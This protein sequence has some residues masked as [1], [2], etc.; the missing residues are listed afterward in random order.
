M[1]DFR[2]VVHSALTLGFFLDS[3]GEPE[4]H[5]T[6]GSW[7]DLCGMSV[8][9]AMSGLDDGEGGGGQSGKTKNII[10]FTMQK[11]PDNEYSLYLTASQVPNSDV[12]VSFTMDGEPK[13]VTIPA[14]TNML[15]TGLK[16]KNPSKP[17]AVIS[18]AAANSDDEQYTYSTKNTVKTGIFTLTLTVDGQ[19]ETRQVPYGETVDLVAPAEREGY[20]FVWKDGN[21]NVITGNTFEMPESDASVT[22]TYVAKSYVLTYIVKE[23]VLNGDSVSVNTVSTK[24]ATIKFGT[25][26][27]NTIKNETPAKAGYT[28]DGWKSSD[29]NV[30]SATTMPAKDFEVS[31]TY[32]LNKYTLTFKADGSTISSEQKY[33]GQ[34]I[35]APSIPTKT[36]Y[37]TV[38]WDKNVP[39]AMPASNLTFN[40]VYEAIKYYIRYSVDGTEKYT[41]EHIYGDAISIRTNESKVGYTFSGWNPSTL[42]A[43]MPAED[44][45]VVGTFA[46][47]TYHL[48]VYVDGQVYFEKDY[49]YEDTIDKSEIVDPT[50]EGYTFT[51]WEPEIPDTV[52]ANDLEI[53]AKFQI[54]KYL[55]SYYVDN[56]LVNSALTDYNAEIVP[57]AEPT[58][59]GYTFSGWNN[60]PANM[61]ASDVRIDGTFSINSYTLTYFVS[62]ETYATETH[63]YDEPITPL[64]EPTKEGYTFS[65][66]DEVPAKM[67]ARDVDVN[68]T[69][70]VNT[71]E[72]R[73][74]V[75]GNP[76]LTEEHNYGEAIQLANVPDE[77]VGYTFS[78]WTYDEFPATMPNHNIEV[79][80]VFNV[81]QY[82]LSFVLDGEPYTSIT[83]DYDTAITAPTVSAKTGYTF[84]GWNPAVPAKMPA[85]DT[86]F[87][88]TYNINSWTATYYIDGQ[89]YTA[90]TYQYGATI[91][92]PDVPRDGYIL[93]WTKEYTE[94]PDKDINIAGI[95]E[96]KVDSKEVYYG[97]IYSSGIT[98]FNNVEALDS[99]EYVDGEVQRANFVIPGSSEYAQIED[100]YNDGIIGDDEWD[101][102]LEAHNYHY[103]IFVPAKATFASIKNALNIEMI[104][105]FTQRPGV[106]VINE[107]DYNVYTKNANTCN[108][109][110]DTVYKTTI[111][112]ED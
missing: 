12:V 15:S 66:W 107:T 33:F 67:P 76:Y 50:K 3:C 82:T 2:D 10:T 18:S 85:Q 27:W 55:L 22:G 80:G 69:F 102:W 87:N 52:P 63:E 75:D 70:I 11:G 86:T 9:E 94:M 96:E 71:W 54:N 112:I 31:N 38:G 106:T 89:Q 110:D 19:K 97:M 88:G 16:G 6:W 103:I 30:T 1:G 51:G 4:R 93:K 17:Y 68:G 47:N 42:P 44:I 81:N 92:Y 53:S 14:G 91:S 45:S 29:G 26:I 39:S 78:G 56:E 32:K 21:G 72:I 77:R 73:Y 111:K 20:D 108:G 105:Q 99:Y 8:D 37:S 100:D 13:L 62:G 48:T 7:I 95:Y 34:A 74:L 23:E 35:S 104:G 65:G 101:A 83:A 90:I 5:Y 25:K 79:N 98:T 59:E 58:K 49:E 61:P 41:E 36:G 40:A 60:V 46:K 109:R 24:T 43:T 64:A 28:L 57:I 84:S